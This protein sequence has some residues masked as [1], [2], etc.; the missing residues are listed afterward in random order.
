MHGPAVACYSSIALAACAFLLTG[1]LLAVWWPPAWA[2]YIGAALFVLTNGAILLRWAYE[3]PS[4]VR[5]CF[6]CRYDMSGISS[7]TCPECG[8][9]GEDEKAVRR[10]RWPAEQMGFAVGI[11]VCF[12]LPAS[13]GAAVWLRISQEY[14]S[15]RWNSSSITETQSRGYEIAAALERFHADNGAFPP[16]L[17][18]LEPKYLAHIPPPT[19]GP[20]WWEYGTDGTDFWLGAGANESFYPAMY[21]EELYGGW[22]VDQ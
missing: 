20:P 4:D 3:A 21:L 19:A 17:D 11:I 12:V 6:R 9:T 2:V 22:Y 15:P 16:S 8:W 14:F 5:A 13:V 1:R 7:L 18:A 10:T